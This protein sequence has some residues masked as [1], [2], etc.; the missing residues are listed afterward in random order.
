MQT[1][2]VGLQFIAISLG[3]SETCQREKSIELKKLN[4]KFRLVARFPGPSPPVAREERGEGRKR[5]REGIS[6][7]FYGFAAITA[8]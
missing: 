8:L 4:Q 7:E 5:S 1:Y 2:I 6:M 3:F